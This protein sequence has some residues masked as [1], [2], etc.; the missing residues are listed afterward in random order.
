VI[1]AREVKRTT[2][3]GLLALRALSNSLLR[4]RGERTEEKKGLDLSDLLSEEYDSLIF[5]PAKEA[6][7]LTK[8]FI[9]QFQKPLQLIVPD[10]N[11]RQ[12][13]KVHIRHPELRHLPRVM[14]REPNKA[15]H[16]LRAENTEYGMS[17]LLAIAKALTV[18]EGQ[19]VG[20]KLQ[21]LYELK[22][23]RTLQGRGIK[24]AR[25]EAGL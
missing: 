4:V 18:I 25:H 23:E 6:Q 3:T 22:L 20:Q 2:N 24:K 5:Y 15:L 16:H 10:G 12:A 13:S 14:I 17:T 1:H 7:E 21:A 9:S 11:W 8:E 19:E